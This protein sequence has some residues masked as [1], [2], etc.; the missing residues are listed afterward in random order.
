[1]EVVLGRHGNST[2]AVPLPA[3]PKDPGLSAGQAMT[4]N[5]TEQCL[6]VLDRKRRYL[7]DDAP[8]RSMAPL[9]G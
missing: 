5:T 9:D 8:G 2:V 1:M 7:L 3:V 6:I 4:L